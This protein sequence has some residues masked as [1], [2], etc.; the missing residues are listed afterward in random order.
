MTPEKIKQLHSDSAYFDADSVKKNMESIYD[1]L[2]G[3]GDVAKLTETIYLMALVIE[4][5]Q[6][7]VFWHESAIES[8][9]YPNH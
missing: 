3:A 7:E 4:R 1:N 8:L 5:L 6:S 9:M 2:D